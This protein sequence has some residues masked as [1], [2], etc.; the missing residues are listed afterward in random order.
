MHAAQAPLAWTARPTSGLPVC[1][2][3]ALAAVGV[4][5]LPDSTSRSQ[6]L[7]TCPPRPD[8]P[9]RGLG[10]RLQYAEVVQRRLHQRLRLRLL[11]RPLS[12]RRPRRHCPAPGRRAAASVSTSPSLLAPLARQSP[13]VAAGTP[14]WGA[15]EPLTL[16]QWHLPPL[17]LPPAALF[18]PCVGAHAL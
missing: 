6:S 12:S 3:Y 8:P 17:V 14:T 18:R 13:Y 11:P 9:S 15:R 7:Q 4:W 10:R 5:N 2:T 16:A 1:V